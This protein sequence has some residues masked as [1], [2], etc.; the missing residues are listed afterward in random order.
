MR[1]LYTTRSKFDSLPTPV[2]IILYAGIAT[3]IAM[4]SDDAIAAGGAIG[5]YIPVA[6]GILGNILA[7]KLLELKKVS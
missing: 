2:K 1:L 7:W 6:L 4:V 3:M 5:R